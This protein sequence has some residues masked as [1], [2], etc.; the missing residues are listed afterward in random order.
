MKPCSMCLTR[1]GFN[2][3]FETASGVDSRSNARS[4]AR[5]FH[6]MR[7]ARCITQIEPRSLVVRQCVWSPK[8]RLCEPTMR[9]FALI[10]NEVG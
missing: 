10:R 8:C 1:L 4:N 7:R 2:P 6:E 9:E 5:S 3:F